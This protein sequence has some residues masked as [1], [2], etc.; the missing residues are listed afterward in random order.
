MT[1]LNKLKLRIVAAI[2]TVTPQMLE[3]NWK[4]TEYRLDILH[5]T[6][7]AHV[8]VIYHAMVLILQVINPSVQLLYSLNIFI[9]LLTV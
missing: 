1:S 8:E 7:G 3:N 5:T 6:K 2:E 4:E 9:Y